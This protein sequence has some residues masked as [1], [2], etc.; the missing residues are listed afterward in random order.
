MAFKFSFN[1]A[2]ALTA[3]GED[4]ADAAGLNPTGFRI[5][6]TESKY[7]VRFDAGPPLDKLHHCGD[8]FTSKGGGENSLSY[9]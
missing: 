3:E 4:A 9:N 5:I 6:L 8:C 2:T 1:L 7:C